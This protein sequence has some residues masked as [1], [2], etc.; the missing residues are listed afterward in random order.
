MLHWNRG[1]DRDIGPA[2][3]ADL[4]SIRSWNHNKKTVIQ[5]YVFRCADLILYIFNSC[6]TERATV[7]IKVAGFVPR[8]VTDAP[9][10]V[11]GRCKVAELV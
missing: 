1:H 5:Y 4:I 2:G 8:T 10:V 6:E 9:E 11:V 7:C 3:H